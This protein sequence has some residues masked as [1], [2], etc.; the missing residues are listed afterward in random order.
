MEIGADLTACRSMVFWVG[1]LVLLG[2][3]RTRTGSALLRMRWLGRVDCYR[4][5][6]GWRRRGERVKGEGLRPDVFAR[7]NLSLS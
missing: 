7:L 2:S 3:S 5:L 6:V 1:G 4:T